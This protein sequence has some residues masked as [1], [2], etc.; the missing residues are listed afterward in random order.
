MIRVSHS[1]YHHIIE[2]R[3]LAEETSSQ[4][5][6]SR[7]KLIEIF[8][9]RVQH[10]TQQIQELSTREKLY[11]G[12]NHMHWNGICVLPI[13]GSAFF[14]LMLL[15]VDSKKMS[16]VCGIISTIIIIATI[17]IPFILGPF[18]KE[19]FSLNQTLKLHHW[20]KK[21]EIDSAHLVEL[22]STEDP[23]TSEEI[24]SS[25]KILDTHA[26]KEVACAN[27]VGLISLDE[28][29][30]LTD[31][32]VIAS[33][34]S[35]KDK[36]TIID[37]LS[38]PQILAAS[39]IESGFSEMI[40]SHFRAEKN[41]DKFHYL[42]GIFNEV[43]KIS[44]AASFK[45]LHHQCCTLLLRDLLNTITIPATPEW[46]SQFEPVASYR[47]NRES[48]NAILGL[49]H[50]AYHLNH[51]HP[52]VQPQLSEMP[53]FNEFSPDA[54]NELLE[55]DSFCR[56]KNLR[57]AERRLCLTKENY[58][59]GMNELWYDHLRNIDI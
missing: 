7:E 6:I 17:A 14:A 27:K 9:A 13:I 45:T 5:G 24:D 20:G 3:S 16:L 52:E 56:S 30:P 34:P 23:L 55:S 40:L 57:L 31:E 58:R 35:Y 38:Y 39:R 49:G 2:M 1:P 11:C 43:Y 53:M 8:K 36:T 41:P 33:Q 26:V 44:N 10:S 48:W 37:S 59:L 32:G 54:S 18:D 19:E 46:F 47:D 12:S 51:N 4:T 28:D 25:L 22:T 50:Y 21:R 42:H 15:S 29:P